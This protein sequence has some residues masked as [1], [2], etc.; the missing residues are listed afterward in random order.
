MSKLVSLT[1][2]TFL[3]F[4]AVGSA[5]ETQQAAAPSSAAASA[6]AFKIPPEETQRANKVKPTPASLAEGKHVYASQCAMCHGN[7]GDGKGDLAADMKLQLRDYRDPD[8]LKKFTD[9]ELFYIL[10]KGKGD[11]PGTEDRMKETQ[12]WDLV[13][14]LRSLLR[15]KP[16]TAHGN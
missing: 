3:L 16:A 14:Y 15:K 5:Q 9:G 6:T 7:T 11:M 13:N 4:V 2:I 8:A 1:A 12:R 10:T